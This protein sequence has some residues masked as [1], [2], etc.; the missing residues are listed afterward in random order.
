MLAER[1]CDMKPIYIVVVIFV[2]V[3][4]V[5]VLKICK[6]E[7]DLPNSQPTVDIMVIEENTG[8]VY[9]NYGGAL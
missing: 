5:A 7:S 8:L 2:I 1:T 3:F 4:G 6:F 9:N